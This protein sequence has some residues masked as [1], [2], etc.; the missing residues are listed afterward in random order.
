MLTTNR[1]CTDGII[2]QLAVPLKR[3]VSSRLHTLQSSSQEGRNLQVVG[4][5]QRHHVCFLSIPI[6]IT[7]RDMVLS[8]KVQVSPKMQRLTPKN[9]TKGVARE[10]AVSS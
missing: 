3:N 9:E 2:H 5:I 8:N 10:F 7:P 6:E 1:I 4:V